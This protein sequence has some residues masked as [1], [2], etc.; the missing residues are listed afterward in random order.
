MYTSWLILVFYIKKD[1]GKLIG[2]NVY[3]RQGSSTAIATPE[4]VAE[5]GNVISQDGDNKID[6]KFSFYYDNNQITPVEI[7]EYSNVF[8]SP[9]QDSII[10]R[11]DKSEK[12]NILAIMNSI[13]EKNEY[14]Y[15]KELSSWLHESSLYYP[16]K[17]YIKSESKVPIKKLEAKS[18]IPFN[19]IFDFKD[20]F[21]ELSPLNKQYRNSMDSIRNYH[22]MTYSDIKVVFDKIQYNWIITINIELLRPDEEIVTKKYLF[23]KM[24]NSNEI[25]LNFKVYG[26]NIPKAIEKSLKIKSII[27]NRAMTL[28]DLLQNEN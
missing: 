19:S 24:I 1:Y 18:I 10:K 15:Y 26:E 9:F 23:I 28:D 6:I 12:T 11:F 27:S 4:E 2:G 7:F 14:K 3:Y 16:L 17:F 5:M 8:L 20:G 21:S 25:N 22:L 13:G